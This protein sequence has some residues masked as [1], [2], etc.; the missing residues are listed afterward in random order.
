MDR[1]IEISE[2]APVIR[3]DR[4]PKF[5]GVGHQPDTTQDL[6][7]AF[8]GLVGKRPDPAFSF[9]PMKQ[10][11][12]FER[13]LIPADLPLQLAVLGPPLTDLAFLLQRPPGDA[14]QL[15][16]RVI[17]FGVGER[18]VSL[19]VGFLHMKQVKL[20]VHYSPHRVIPDPDQ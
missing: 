1:F 18:P 15:G 5:R 20:I 3:P 11:H 13:L 19:G 14:R 2:K 10:I 8:F 17:E 9:D 16:Y 7:E 4:Q 6:M 12:G